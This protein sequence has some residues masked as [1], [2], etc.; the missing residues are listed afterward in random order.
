MQ[1]VTAGWG[2]GHANRRPAPLLER[3]DLLCPSLTWPRVVGSSGAPASAQFLLPLPTQQ[4]SVLWPCPGRPPYTSPS[5]QNQTPGSWSWG[6]EAAVGPHHSL[7][8]FLYQPPS[9]EPPRVAPG[10]GT[11]FGRSL[12]R[13]N[14]VGSPGTG[15]CAKECCQSP[16]TEPS[17]RGSR[18]LQTHPSWE[19]R[20]KRTGSEP[21]FQHIHTHTGA[22]TCAPQPQQMLI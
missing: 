5:W 18:F 21:H 9:P 20:A 17:P 6:R 16:G 1:M 4:P 7:E 22:C 8:Y 2:G 15:R 13:S 3:E 11:L 10:T 12:L 14:R 19:R